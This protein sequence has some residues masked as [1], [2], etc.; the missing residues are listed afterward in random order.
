MALT[1]DQELERARN[2]FNATATGKE[3]N[4][5]REREKKEARASITVPDLPMGADYQGMTDADSIAADT[6]SDQQKDIQLTTDDDFLPTLGDVNT[7]YDLKEQAFQDQQ[8]GIT[9]NA[10]DVSNEFLK[11]NKVTVRGVDVA[12]GRRVLNR[13]DWDNEEA[14]ES[15]R[16]GVDE[17]RKGGFNSQ[18]GLD[19]KSLRGIT[20]VANGILAEGLSKLDFMRSIDMLGVPKQQAELAWS[21]ANSARMQG[22]V[23]AYLGQDF[24]QGDLDDMPP[25]PLPDIDKEDLPSVEGWADAAKL[26]YETDNG[27]PFQ[28]TDQD[29]IDW[30]VD[31]MSSFNWKM[32]NVDLPGVNTSSMGSYLMSAMS[33]GPEYAQA[34]S[35]MIDTYDRV[36]TDWSIVG[37]S[38]LSL[39]GDPTTYVGLGGGFVA[40]R[41]GAQVAK[42]RMKRV[43]QETIGKEI[44]EAQVKSA[45]KA[46]MVAG[47]AA[48]GS[49]EG[50]GF[51]AADNAGRQAVRVEAGEQ[52]EIDAGEVAGAAAV[53]AG[54]GAAVGAG[55]PVVAP[56]LVAGG[57]RVGRKLLENGKRVPQGKMYR[58]I[59][60]VGDIANMRLPLASSSPD[61]DAH[62]NLRNAFDFASSAQFANNRE[63]K[64]GL[65]ALAKE[66]MKRA[67]YNLAIDNPD[68]NRILSDMMVQDARTAMASNA[69]AVGW[70]DKTVGAAMEILS[71]IHPEISTDKRAKFAFTYALAVT[72]NGLKVDKNF[73][74]AEKAYRQWKETGVMPDDIGTG[75]AAGAINKSLRDYN[76]LEKEFGPEMLAEIM[77]QK[78]TIRQLEGI[79]GTSFAGETKEAIVRG[80]MV[81]GPKIGNGFFSNLNGRFDALTI[82]RWFMRSWGRLTGTLIEPRPDMVKEKSATL[83]SLVK[84]FK[85][86]HPDLVKEYQ[87][88]GVRFNLNNPKQMAADIQKAS[89]L[90]A[91]R[92]IMNRTE[93]GQEI[94]KTGNGLKKYLE[95]DKEAPNGGKERAR[96]RGVMEPAL[97]ELQKDYPELTMS[98]L[99]AV[100]WYPEKRLYDKA[101]AAEDVAEGY[102]DDE[103]PDY[104]NAAAKLASE[105]G[106]DDKAIK[107]AD[108]RGRT[109]GTR[110]GPGGA[111][112]Q[113]EAGR[114]TPQ[115]KRRAELLKYK[116]FAQKRPRFGGNGKARAYGKPS[117]RNA[118]GIRGV[119]AVHEPSSRFSDLMAATEAPAVTLHELNPKEM[120]V[121]FTDMITRN[122]Q[123]SKF[124]AAVY[125]YSPEEYA[126]MRLF[127]TPDG[128]SGFAIKEDG[129]IVSV[130]S[131]GG[132]NVHSMIQLAV[133]E[134][135]RK[136]DAFDTVLPEIYGI[137]GFK[138]VNRSSWNPD[139][140]PEN[141]DAETFKDF[142]NGEPDVV[143]M[144]YDPNYTPKL[145][146]DTD[147]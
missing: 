5:S 16:K 54:V 64:L 59:G 114:K 144:E 118:R 115:G 30:Y 101:K 78:W 138:E 76:K 86:K 75:T 2:R 99:Q 32:G 117:P 56:V 77:D 1:S 14:A 89:M 113:Q 129:D 112:A 34:L 107:E 127:T 119:V 13:G 96:I 145:E 84:E 24:T 87:A 85:S 83:K 141:W 73:Q 116:L 98:D 90:P 69:N 41:V 88:L 42:Q 28:G 52:D 45:G 36:N 136:L 25:E 20:M 126:N 37:N 95:G 103:A 134:G 146:L 70:Y 58:Q 3:I 137:N 23:E 26:V 143:F 18:E 124:G 131:G 132:G 111:E 65:Q 71:E 66:S 123:G 120:A 121:D 104:A 40:A 48:G 142:N 27:V 17:I 29:L 68:N 74:L 94:R 72:S 47:A 61:W 33:N 109:T 108:S 102:A 105:L 31:E 35:S 128:G 147:G 130:F 19:E 133:Q 139:Y 50:A 51:T 97:K 81:L 44:T 125:V 91:N 11:P 12:T 10:G 49:F 57:R 38:L 55:I 80:S 106:V 7:R 100:L 110:S 79:F 53:G 135:G 21:S 140:A 8:R 82:D 62:T 122:K 4:L 60:A 63:L 15:Y 46:G 6:P 39:L 22:D 43:L 9:R 93:L 67:G 92:E